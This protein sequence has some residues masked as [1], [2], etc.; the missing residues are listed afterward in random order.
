[1]G[2]FLLPFIDSLN[3]HGDDS[4]TDKNGNIT[5]AAKASGWTKD[6]EG[7]VIFSPV[8]PK[9]FQI[10]E[11]EK[12][13][14][15][16]EEKAADREAYWEN[17]QRTAAE[18][19]F[20]ALKE[21]GIDAWY[22]KEAEEMAYAFQNAPEKMDEVVDKI[23]E[24]LNTEDWKTREDLPA[25]WWLNGG[26]WSGATGNSQQDGIT[27]GDLQSFRNLP[28]QLQRAAQ[29][30]TASGVS[31]IRVYLDGAVVGRL[32]APY[33]SAEIAYHSAI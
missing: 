22:G 10:P 5:E 25:E 20:D 11:S 4:I 16:E 28:A 26:Q 21:N 19:L 15:T 14:R 23:T 6:T 13:E 24:L 8:A 27:S 30:G 2:G 18:A 1:M 3:N 33:V 9:E 31:G 12:D 29:N 7:N 17:R 32:V